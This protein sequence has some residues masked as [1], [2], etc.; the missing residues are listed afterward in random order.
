MISPFFRANGYPPDTK[1]YADLL[2]NNFSN[3]KL[4]IYGLVEKPLEFSLVG[5]SCL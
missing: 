5:Y 2:E 3:W 1:E 4:K